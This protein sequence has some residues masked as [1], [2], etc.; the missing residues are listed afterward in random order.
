MY[1]RLADHFLLHAPDGVGRDLPEQSV[2]LV[3]PWLQVL[4]RFRALSL[5]NYSMSVG[6]QVRT[7]CPAYAAGWGACAVIR[8]RLSHSEHCEDRWIR[9]QT[10]CHDIVRDVL[11]KHVQ[12]NAHFE[13][14]REAPNVPGRHERSDLLL[15]RLHAGPGTESHYDLFIREVTGSRMERIR[16]HEVM[17][18]P[19]G[20]SHEDM[21][22]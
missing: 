22:E 14:K 5:Q 21:G 10:L 1:K 16:R 6:L 13:V 12:R 2:P 19:T 17:L 15:R 11:Y 20:R 9:G 4:P 8:G 3:R 18:K 7:M